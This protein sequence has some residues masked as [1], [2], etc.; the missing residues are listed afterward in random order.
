MSNFY[1]ISFSPWDGSGE[2]DNLVKWF[3]APTK[4]I[5]ENWL[6][7]NGLFHHV[8]DFGIDDSD[9]NFLS[10]EPDYFGC[11]VDIVFHSQNDYYVSP[12]TDPENWLDEIISAK[13]RQN[14]A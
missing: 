13:Q 9:L 10:G 12:N 4:Q 5:V 2:Y 6:K 3:I 1:Q 11:G 8:D 7:E 14:I